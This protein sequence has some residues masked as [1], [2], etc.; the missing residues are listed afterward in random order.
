[1]QQ[2]NASGCMLGVK[3]MVM[4]TANVDPGAPLAFAVILGNYTLCFC[5]SC[6]HWLNGTSI[7]DGAGLPSY[8][9]SLAKIEFVIYN[10]GLW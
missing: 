4:C 1:M 7:D 6:V 3:V 8:N 5:G 10:A 9:V 2:L